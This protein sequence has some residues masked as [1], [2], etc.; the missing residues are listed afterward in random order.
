M[1]NVSLHNR[2]P[3]ATQNKP[4]AR[5]QMKIR[6]SAQCSKFECIYSKD[7][8]E[9]QIL[10][11]QCWIVL[12][13]SISQGR[14][15]S[16]CCVSVLCKSRNTKRRKRNQIQ[17]NR[18]KRRSQQRLRYRTTV[19]SSRHDSSTEEMRWRTE[20]RRRGYDAWKVNSKNQISMR[21]Q[22]SMSEHDHTL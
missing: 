2:P 10:F 6:L 13:P 4:R 9:F 21:N 5:G 19:A 7:R 12:I 11:V 3:R 20:K 16:P 14:S 1:Q 8:K 22:R 15:A 17:R 18:Q